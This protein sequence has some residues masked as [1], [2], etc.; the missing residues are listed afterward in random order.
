MG[1]EATLGAARR[2][3]FIESDRIVD[4]IGRAFSY[5]FQGRRLPWQST[6]THCVAR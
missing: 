2:R 4:W 5:R 3:G 1:V 6:C